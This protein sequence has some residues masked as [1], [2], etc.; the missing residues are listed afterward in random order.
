MRRLSPL[1]FAFACFSALAQ[2]PAAA[3]PTGPIPLEHFTRFDEFSG[4]KISPDGEFVAVLTG[5]YG[6]SAILFM[7]LKSKKGVS[8]IRVPED[9]EIDEYHWISPTRMVYT[10]AQRQREN[11]RPTPTG[12]IFAINR[13]GSSARQLYGYRA[14]QSSMD[15]RLAARKASYATPEILSALKKDPDH[16]LIAEYPWRNAGNAWYFNPDAKPLISRLDVYSGRSSS[17][18][19]RRS[20]TPSFCW[21]TTTTYASRSA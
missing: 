12:E 16:I 20:P 3:P 7:E 17:W 9:C 10:I 5:K 4:L 6:R 21:I 15:T 14:E 11:V 13:D 19:W 8:S 1:L 2:T 18:T